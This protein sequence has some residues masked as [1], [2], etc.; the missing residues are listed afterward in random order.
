MIDAY[1]DFRTIL[2]RETAGTPKLAIATA[3]NQQKIFL[4]GSQN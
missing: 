3:E 1:F 4:C 2:F